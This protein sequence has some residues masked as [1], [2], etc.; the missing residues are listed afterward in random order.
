MYIMLVFK[1]ESQMC[2]RQ[3]ASHREYRFSWTKLRSFSLNKFKYNITTIGY[4]IWE[5]K[6]TIWIHLLN[7]KTG[8]RSKTGSKR[9]RIPGLPVKKVRIRIRRGEMDINMDSDIHMYLRFLKNISKFHQNFIKNTQ[10]K[11]DKPKRKKKTVSW[12]LDTKSIN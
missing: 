4:T 12:D 5:N 1:P 7:W 3:T 6:I 10:K 11:H 8:E 9:P 2:N